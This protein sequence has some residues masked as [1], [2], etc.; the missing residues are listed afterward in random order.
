MSSSTVNI[1]ATVGTSE[2]VEEFGRF[3]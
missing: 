3:T 1:T 2:S